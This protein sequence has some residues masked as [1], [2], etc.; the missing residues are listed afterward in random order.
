MEKNKPARRAS[1]PRA[2]APSP[3]PAA[4]VPNGFGNSLGDALK[5]ALEKHQGNA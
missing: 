1:V 4:S 5:A 3:T 2:K